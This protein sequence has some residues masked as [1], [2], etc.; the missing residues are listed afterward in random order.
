MF[1]ELLPGNVLIKSVKIVTIY[2]MGHLNY[3]TEYTYAMVKSNPR[4]DSR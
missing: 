2:K 3:N 4:N 1:T